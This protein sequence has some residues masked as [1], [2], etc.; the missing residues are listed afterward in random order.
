MKW[1]RRNGLSRGV[2]ACLVALAIL[3]IL[4]GCAGSGPS[5]SSLPDGHAA[6]LALST[7]TPTSTP[8]SRPLPPPPPL[9]AHAAYLLNPDTGQVYLAVNANTKLAMA[10][11]TKIMTA[12]V[13]L[14]YGKLDQDIT[15]GADAVA[16]QNGIASVA[17]VQLGDKIPLRALLYALLLPSGDDAAVVI[18]DG[19]AGSQAR[20]VQLMNLEVFLLGMTSTHYAN[21]HGLDAPNHYTTA[22]DLA[23]LAL[24]AMRYS[25]F[26]QVVGT[27]YFTLPASAAHAAYTWTT[28]DL[29]LTT[30]R[31]PGVTGIKTGFTGNAGACLAFSATRP[32]GKLIGVV[33]GEPDELSRFT[34][35]AT[36]LNWGFGI[37]QS[38]QK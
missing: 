10:S 22:H 29:L 25:A 6:K 28:T 30:L 37:E 38:Q 9:T 14:T 12:V 26:R 3:L 7:V 34:D 19:I 36:L 11:T 17:G 35:A 8:P 23:I 5:T 24:F 4:A 31:Y 18:A 2:S 1:K 33:L 32:S 16:L 27:P 21:V 15:V 13:A 20:F